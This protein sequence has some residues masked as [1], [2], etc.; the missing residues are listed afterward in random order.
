MIDT[1]DL[2]NP[3]NLNKLDMNEINWFKKNNIEFINSIPFNFNDNDNDNDKIF[4][5]KSILN[6]NELFFKEISLMFDHRQIYEGGFFIMIG[7]KNP[8]PS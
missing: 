1:N 3:I 6:K 4:D 5:K 7:K 2:I 8:N